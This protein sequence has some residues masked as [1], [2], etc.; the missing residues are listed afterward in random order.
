MAELL[1]GT[2]RGP[3]TKPWRGSRRDLARTF[4]GSL[5]LAILP[6]SRA[7]ANVPTL[8]K[9]PGRPRIAFDRLSFPRGLQGTP[10][11][12]RH[13]ERVLK[14]EGHRAD[15]G[16]GRGS[17]IT[18]RFTIEE[19]LLR[20]KGTALEVRCSA[21]GELPKRRAARSRLVYSGDPGKPEELVKRVIGIVARGVITRLAE[22][23]RDRRGR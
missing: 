11:S 12:I 2:T 7:S 5:V 1:S 18:F 23:E 8:G 22:L 16:A 6:T 4:A 14:H 13:L 20:P 10:T 17:T 19:L 9:P 21:R 15:W 3:A